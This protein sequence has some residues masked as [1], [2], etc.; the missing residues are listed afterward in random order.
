[1]TKY[2]KCS[3]CGYTIAITDDS[4]AGDYMCPIDGTVL[5]DATEAEHEHVLFRQAA[6]FIVAA[7]D[8]LH[9]ERADYV[10]PGVDDQVVIQAAIDALGKGKISLLEGT[11]YIS[12]TI[13]LK[14]P[15]QIEGTGIHTTILRMMGGSNKDMFEFK[16]TSSSLFLTISHLTLYGNNGNNTS[17][18][19]IVI[20]NINGGEPKD[21]RLL[22]LYLYSFPDCG[23]KSDTGWGYK[24]T[25]VVIEFSDYGIYL[26]KQASMETT[27]TGCHITSNNNNLYL[28]AT[29]VHILG[30]E[31]SRAVIGAG[32]ELKGGNNQIVGAT[33]FSN[34]GDGIKNTGIENQI[35]GCALIY[36]EGNGVNCQKHY[37]SISN[38]CMESNHL[39]G[40][41]VSD[42]HNVLSNLVVANNKHNGID[43]QA[44]FCYLSNSILRNNSID[45]P[46]VYAGLLS[47][48][49]F[50][51][52]NNLIF[53]G[54]TMKYGLFLDAASAN[55]QLSSIKSYG[56]LTAEI[57]NSGSNNR[58]TDVVGY[59]TK[60]SGTSTGTG[61]QQTIA[62]GLAATPTKVILWNIEDGAN[63]YQSAAA[64]GTNI[65]ITAVINQD[66]G[67]EAEVV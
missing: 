45:N 58:F 7:S 52:F 35:T 59:V 29:N 60:K 27:L 10:C 64:D 49:S 63:P 11:Y 14:S 12:D 67:W 32:I 24:F 37:T 65:K 19:G 15:L 33:M 6:T 18:N 51:Y 5:V 34:K 43:I 22:D 30:G 36:N 50:D 31:Y 4:D 39:N 8:S 48:G 53:L 16:P 54:N 23:I 3:V 20:S 2:A 41:S 57:Q 28:D 38:C 17:G 66:Y 42:D 47:N 1:M 40:I 25:N 62:H 56:A 61:A 26:N 46:N 21:V 55:N 44:N 13:I 9:K